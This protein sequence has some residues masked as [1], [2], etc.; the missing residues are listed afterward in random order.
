MLVRIATWVVFAVDVVLLYVL[1]THDARVAMERDYRWH[2][3][4]ISN[5]EY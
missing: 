4:H 5:R 1:L 2:R 3:Q